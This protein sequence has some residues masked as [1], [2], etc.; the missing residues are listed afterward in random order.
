M[1]SPCID[2]GSES[3]RGTISDYTSLRRMPTGRYLFALGQIRQR[4]EA[5]QDERVPERG[6]LIERIDAAIAAGNVARQR[7]FEWVR[8]RNRQ[9]AAR[10]EAVRVDNEVDVQISA[11]EAIVRARTVGDDG[12]RV[13]AAQNIK[14]QVFPR[15]VAVITNQKFEV[16]LS[17][18]DA[19]LEKLRGPLADAMRHVGIDE[20]VARLGRLVEQFR[21]E[22]GK[23]NDDSVTY[24]QV[25]EARESLHEQT[26]V[27]L[28]SVL[29]M[30]PATD[31]AATRTR[32]HLL[33]PLN[34]Q[35]ERVYE[36]QR[37]HRAPLDVDPTTG[38]VIR[39]EDDR[40]DEP[41]AP[42]AP[43]VPTAG[44]DDA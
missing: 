3:M 32:E 17:L 39:E 25:K 13:A 1:R 2:E 11:I 5:A 30:V 20:E 31:E 41:D 43:D 42:D 37:R 40:E 8:T 38:E 4:V 6:L 12:E 28:V 9:N 26:A 27:V 7:D 35:Q 22:L 10:G 21:T 19:M 15:G 23:A 34:D 16:Q 29:S 33:A 14:E 44:G 24:D 18:L 36:A